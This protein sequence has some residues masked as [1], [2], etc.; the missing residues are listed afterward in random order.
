MRQEFEWRLCVFEIRGPQPASRR[1]TPGLA[2]TEIS[3][4]TLVRWREASGATHEVCLDSD[5]F[6]RQKS[7]NPRI[8]SGLDRSHPRQTIRWRFFLT[9]TTWDSGLPGDTVYP[10]TLKSALR[11][12]GL[13][14]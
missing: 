11:Q 9:G 4:Q 3:R 12:A 5:H 10:K 7:E 8:Y 6:D 2:T 1:W 13:E 14:D